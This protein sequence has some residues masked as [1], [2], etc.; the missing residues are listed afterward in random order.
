MTLGTSL[1]IVGI[2]HIVL[3]YGH[4]TYIALVHGLAWGMGRR[5]QAVSSL[6][7]GRRFERTIANNMESLTA[8]VPITVGAILFAE[9]SPLTAA[10]STVYVATRT[11]FMLCYLANIPF[12]RTL[13]W[14]AG[15]LAMVAIAVH[16]GEA[17]WLDHSPL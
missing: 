8:F 15:Q 7:L 12:V 1:L 4:G 14:F 3:L 11:A 5:D 17:L 16:L 6:D 13:F 9:P 10:A 2:L